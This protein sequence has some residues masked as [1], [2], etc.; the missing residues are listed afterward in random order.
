M[1][2]K[3]EKEPLYRVELP[4]VEHKYLRRHIYGGIYF[5]RFIEDVE[6]NEIQF[7]ESEIRAIDDGYWQF[8]VPVEEVECRG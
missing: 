3:V 5:S 4:A 1:T 8:A 2:V 7:T 6:P